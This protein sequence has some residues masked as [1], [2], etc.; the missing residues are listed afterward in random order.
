VTLP[1]FEEIV[2]DHGP[3]VLRVCRALLG[4]I[5]ADDAWSETF[6]AALRAYPDLRPDSNVRGWLVTIAHNKAVDQLRRSTRTPRPTAEVPEPAPASAAGSATSTALDDDLRRALVALP[7]KQ[8]AAVVHRYLADLSYAEVAAALGTSPA[9]AR[10]SA[11]DGIAALRA[12]YADP[13]PDP[14]GADR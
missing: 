5:D 7:P 8:Q 14:T 6:L 9:A 11:A 10:R 4:P 1:P 12:T 2:D 3:V 13:D